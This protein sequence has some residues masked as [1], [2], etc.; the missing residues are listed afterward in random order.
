MA[1]GNGAVGVAAADAA[2]LAGR[3]TLRLP[4]RQLY[5]LSI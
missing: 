5:Q 3:P 2:I 4:L 1:H